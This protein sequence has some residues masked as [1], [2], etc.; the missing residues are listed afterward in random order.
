MNEE[1]FS[2]SNRPNA[3]VLLSPKKALALGKIQE[4]QLMVLFIFFSDSHIF[5]NFCKRTRNAGLP[6]KPI[7]ILLKPGAFRDLVVD[8]HLP[9][10][11]I[12]VYSLR[13]CE[14]TIQ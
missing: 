5:R 11:Y 2:C 6:T 4:D 7:Y 10:R 3:H 14:V 8:A 12:I 9:I 13:I 1:K